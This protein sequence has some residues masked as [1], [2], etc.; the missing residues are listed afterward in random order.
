LKVEN[1]RKITAFTASLHHC[2]SAASPSTASEAIAAA[3]AA[4][5]LAMRAQD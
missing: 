5:R 3:A 1:N 2:I 4:A